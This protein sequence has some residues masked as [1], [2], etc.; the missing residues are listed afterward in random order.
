[1]NYKKLINECVKTFYGKK[2]NII[3]GISEKY[4]CNAILIDGCAIY[5]LPNIYNPLDVS[6][7]N[8]GKDLLKVDKLFNLQNVKEANITDSMIK[9]G[10]DVFVKFISNDE[11][12]YAYINS[13]Y[14]S[15]FDYIEDYEIFIENPKAPVFFKYNDEVRAMILPVF[16]KEV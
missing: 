15:Y 2:N 14:L 7:C 11:N 12:T 16:H 1:M 8:N 3:Y 13:K 9:N 10:K 6:I 5:L 4:N